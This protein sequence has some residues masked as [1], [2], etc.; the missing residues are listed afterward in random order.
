M[1]A[2][3][4]DEGRRTLQGCHAVGVWSVLAVALATQ[5]SPGAAQP[6]PPAASAAPV[7]P[8]TAKSDA[9]VAS[10]PPSFFASVRPTTALDMIDALP[11]FALDTG[12]A[13]RG[14]GG[15]AGNVL[16]DGERPATKN[17]NLS[18]L[19]IRIAA[20]SVA[21]IDVIRGG[22]PGVD[23]QGKT[24]IANVILKTGEGPKLVAIAVVNPLYNGKTDWGMRLEGSQRTGA[25]SYEASL[26]LVTGPDDGTGDGPH[27]VTSP[28][29]AVLE[30]DLEHYFANA[31]THKVTGAME[32]PFAGGRIR[33]EGSFLNTGYISTNS[34]LSPDPADRQF[35]LF[36]QDQD[37]GEM[38]LRY[39]RRLGPR[40]NL[41]VYALQQLGDYASADGLTTLGD[42][43]TFTL[44][45]RTGE[46]ILRA[47]STYTASPTLSVQAGL[48]GDYNW[49][50]SRTRETDGGR[51]IPVPAADVHV[52]E[53]RGEAFA[54]ATWQAKPGL[55]AEIGAKV[56]ASKI[57]STGDVVSTER[58][59]FP[60][61]RA[62]VTWSPDPTD[63]LQLRLE[64]EVGQLDFGYFAASGTLGTGTHAGNP[65]LITEQDW[66]IEA[67]YDRRFWNGGDASLAL[68]RYWLTDA[69]DF[70]PSC[71]TEA[72]AP[73]ACDPAQEFDTPANIGAGSKQEIAATL[74]LPTDRLGLKGGQLIL[75]ATWRH[76]QVID[77]STGRPRGISGLHPVDAE[78]HYTQGLP[79]LKSVLQVD[80]FSAWR[81]REYHFNEVDTQR[82]GWWADVFIEYRPRPDLSFK[83]E[84]DNL[85]TH[86]LEQVR[87]FYDPF[88]DVG[89]GALS[90]VDTRS[91]RFG[92]ELTLRARKTFG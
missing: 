18:E 30:R 45:K 11:G 5:P 60:K 27:T 31:G 86:G 80:V 59:A 87:A 62:V 10:Y 12:D 3:A 14:F 4:G 70:A 15:A 44:G 33:I 72:L 89:G 65:T 64:R 63:Q 7:A 85:F 9:A 37:T 78:A 74:T 13:V 56:E 90:T 58:L 43:A 20:T 53:L 49:L 8:A 38:G 82:L 66:V 17:D 68:R 48:E 73:G 47:T 54:D 2:G 76:S 25:T 41:E 67:T 26:L 46:S 81:Q 77:P 42:V 34:D 51:P 35:E 92:P 91:P 1:L 24:E 6:A 69:I 23:M 16:I 55:T 84:A 39:D 19:L 21:R 22:A 50:T 57:A 61:P 83:I 28:T 79:A 40:A 36:K 71:V 29:G 32:T 75:R 88:R 52:T